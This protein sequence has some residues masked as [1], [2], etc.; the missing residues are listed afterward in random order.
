[1]SREVNDHTYYQQFLNKINSCILL[2]C[3]NRFIT[4]HPDILQLRIKLKEMP[5][6]ICELLSPSILTMATTL[7]LKFPFGL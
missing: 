6:V 1:M 5:T 4:C 3:I 2:L 7:C